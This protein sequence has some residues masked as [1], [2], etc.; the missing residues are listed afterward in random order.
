MHYHYVIA[1][2]GDTIGYMPFCGDACHRQWC[3]DNGEEYGGWNGCQEGGDYPEW[4]ENCGTF[5]GGQAQ[6]DH[7]LSNMVVN[8]FICD[9]DER[10]ECG[11][12]IQVPVT[13]R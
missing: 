3:A 9:T 1:D 7:Q 2:N 8:R 12:W 10:C 6:C 5:A 11:H 13:R 4:C